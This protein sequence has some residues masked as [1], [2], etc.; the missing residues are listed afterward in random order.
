VWL[1]FAFHLGWNLAQPFYGSNLSGHNDAGFVI[2][3]KFEGP[4]LLTGTAFG[5][6]DSV[7][8]LLIL[9]AISIPI[10]FYCYKHGRSVRL[11][12]TLQAKEVVI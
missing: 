6:E 2:N 11:P 5:I 3:A 9:V 10:T 7:L 4:Q 12:R 1:P 8:S